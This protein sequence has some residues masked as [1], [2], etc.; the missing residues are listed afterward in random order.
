MAGEGTLVSRR[1]AFKGVM[2]IVQK[3]GADYSKKEF[4]EQVRLV[5]M[6]AKPESGLA[7]RITEGMPFKEFGEVLYLAL[8]ARSVKATGG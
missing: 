4:V 3:M 7:E 1:S 2:D 5:V 6:N 8:A